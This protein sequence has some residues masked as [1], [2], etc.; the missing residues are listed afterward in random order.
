MFYDVMTPETHKFQ[1][2]WL[3]WYR[4]TNMEGL[5]KL[6]NGLWYWPLERTSHAATEPCSPF[7]WAIGLLVSA[8]LPKMSTSLNKAQWH[9]PPKWRIQD[10][11]GDDVRWIGSIHGAYFAIFLQYQRS[12][13]LTFKWL[14]A[15]LYGLSIY[16]CV[17]FCFAFRKPGYP[18][19][20]GPPGNPFHW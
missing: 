4:K 5:M 17:L 3:M 9:W 1:L 18:F 6:W 19:W 8:E 15:S 10:Y 2:K 20:A 13:K 14:S 11:S 16:Q 7:W 12:T